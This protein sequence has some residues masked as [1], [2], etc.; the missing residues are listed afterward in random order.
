MIFHSY[1]NVY[2]GVNIH[3]LWVFPWFSYG[4]Y[5]HSY[6]PSHNA[7]ISTSS[8]GG[9]SSTAPQP[10]PRPKPLALLSKV[11]QRPWRPRKPPGEWS[12]WA[13]FMADRE[14]W[15]LKNIRRSTSNLWFFLVFFLLA[16]KKADH[17]FVLCFFFYV[18]YCL[19]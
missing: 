18:F 4:F 11:R 19:S 12:G 13:I 6:Q 14:M 2:Q 7:A 8:P 5:H 15:L 9:P 1:V 17:A 10:S 16:S 3:F